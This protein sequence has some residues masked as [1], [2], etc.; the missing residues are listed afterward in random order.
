MKRSLLALLVAVALV[1]AATPARSDVPNSAF[2]SG[3]ASATGVLA[4]ISVAGPSTCRFS[5]AGTW[6]ATVRGKEEAAG[7]STFVQIPSWDDLNVEYASG[8]TTTGD[9]ILYPQSAGAI[10]ISVTAYTSGTITLSGLNCSPGVAHHENTDSFGNQLTHDSIPVQPSPIYTAPVHDAAPIQPSPL[11][12]IPAQVNTAAPVTQVTA[13]PSCSPVQYPCGQPT[14]LALQPVSTPSAGPA[15]TATTGATYPPNA[16]WDYS[17]PHCVNNGAGTGLPQATP[18]PTVGNVTPCQANTNGLPIVA[19]PVTAGQR[20]IA[21]TGTYLGTWLE[22]EQSCRI[23]FITTSGGSL[24][25]QVIDAFGGVIAGPYTVS[26]PGTAATFQLSTPS[27]VAA[28]YIAVQVTAVVGVPSISLKC[29]TANSTMYQGGSWSDTILNPTAFPSPVP[30]QVFASTLLKAAISDTGGNGFTGASPLPVIT[31]APV[32]QVTAI[33]SC[34]P[35]SYPCGQ[36]TPL[37]LQPVSTPSAAPLPTASP[38]VTAPTQVPM[39]GAQLICFFTSG[40][41]ALS[42]NT[43]YAVKCDK[44]G[45]LSVTTAGR[46]STIASAAVSTCTAVATGA[47]ILVDITYASAAAQTGTL[48]VFNEGATPTCATA[49][50]I[51]VSVA[52]PA[53]GIELPNHF[54]GTGIAYEWLTAGQTGGGKV[55]IDTNP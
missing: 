37:A 26:F 6:V 41:V 38:G 39:V 25:A 34:A 43:T 13:V 27:Y 5:L 17:I 4:A 51:W 21:A 19:L 42:N 50:I 47:E 20:Y 1:F 16:P 14:P 48:E 3:S 29:T 36:P 52:H 8:I 33:P 10:E 55:L 7:S 2:G 49:D 45:N 53:G 15:A 35:V 9:Y 54:A 22:G 31:A 24:T 32:T 40:N 46:S 18:S 28:D 44:M 23:G 11:Y 12:T 30:Y